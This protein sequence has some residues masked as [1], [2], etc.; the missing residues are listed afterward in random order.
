M[1]KFIISIFI[2]S[3][4]ASCQSKQATQR[5]N[6]V[7]FCWLK[8]SGDKVKRAQLIQVSKEF[9]KIPGV[10]EVRAGEMVPSDR[11]IVDSTFDVAIFLSFET[12]ADLNAYIEH[13]DHVSAVKSILKPYTKKVLVYDFIEKLP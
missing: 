8:D 7:V 10:L 2:V 13:P 5:I 3:F 6:H 11:A 9:D 12:E 1:Y 4:L